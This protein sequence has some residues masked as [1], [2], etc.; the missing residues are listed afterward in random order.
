MV[1]RCCVKECKSSQKD[2][3]QVSYFRLPSAD[4]EPQERNKWID[5]LCK[6]NE[7]LVVSTE[8]VV[9]S[10][11]WP[12]GYRVTRKRGH[13]RPFDPPSVF[14]DYIIPTEGRRNHM[15]DHSYTFSQDIFDKDKINFKQLRNR[16]QEDEYGFHEKTVIFEAI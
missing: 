1:K 16:L 3:V 12:L 9:C 5:V 10:K 2:E 4:K 8:T 11:H 6:V 15:S 13:D 14:G 7:Y